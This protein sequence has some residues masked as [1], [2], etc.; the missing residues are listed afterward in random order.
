M[1][2]NAGVFSAVSN[3]AKES[4]PLY[5]T[6]QKVLFHCGIQWRKRIQR[7]MIIPFK[8]LSLPSGENLG[9]ISYLHIQTNPLYG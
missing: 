3:T 4:F 7:R 1:S 8:C 2:H 6:T 5:P 9:K